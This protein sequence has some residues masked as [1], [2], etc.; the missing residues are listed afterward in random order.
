MKTTPMK[1]RVAAMKFLVEV[2]ASGP[3]PATEVSER[4]QSA[5]IAMKTLRRAARAIGVTIYQTGKGTDRQ[6][7]WRLSG[8]ER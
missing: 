4:A 3:V 5:D 8:T 1:L 2:L 6:W 7:F